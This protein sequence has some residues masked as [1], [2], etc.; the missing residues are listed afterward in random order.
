M[1]G[2]RVERSDDGVVELWLDRPAKRNALDRAVVGALADAVADESARAF[3]LA[4]S[5][6]ESAFSAGADLTLADRERAEVSDLLYRLYERMLTSHAPIIAVVEGAAVGGGAQLALASDLRIGGAGAMFRFVGPGHGLAIGAW[7]LPSLVGRGRAL[8]LCLSMRPVAAEAAFELG[9]LDR[10]EAAPRAA[11]VALA[12]EL[13]ALDAGAVAR[14]KSITR[15]A[16]GVLAA[17][18]EER[19]GNHETWSGAV[20]RP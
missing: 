15:T 9:I 5:E 11:A 19:R 8:E 1:A 2:V 13:C 20:G 3:V 14:L 18:E 16:S 10:L 17:L 4:S 7:G 12:H 6:P